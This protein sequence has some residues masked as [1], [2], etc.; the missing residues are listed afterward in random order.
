MK[1]IKNILFSVIA[2]VFAFCFVGCSPKNTTADFTAFNTNVHVETYDKS[3]SAETLNAV[4]KIL[5]NLEAKYSVTA[6]N[7]FTARF[8]ALDANGT[9]TAD[10]ETVFLFNRALTFGALT[11]GKFDFTVYPL[12]KAWRFSPEY[13]VNDF[14]PPT[15]MQI[16]ECLGAVGYGKV[17]V[18]GSEVGKTADGV[19]IDLGGFLKGYAT[20]LIAKKLKQVGVT[21]GYV[22]VG[23]SSLYLFDVDTL[24]VR[25]PENRYSSVLTVKKGLKTVCVSTSGTYERSYEYMGAT[26]THIINPSSGV[27]ADT[28]I[29]SATV[30][31]R[32]GAFADAMTTAL[33]LSS[34]DANNTECEFN[35]LVAKITETDAEA[36]VFAVYNKNGYKAI[37]TNCQDAAGFKIND[38]SYNLIK[39]NV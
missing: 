39:L 3:L 23:G 1:S 34:F 21:Q 28:G 27:P 32:D 33:C 35:R 29:L 25:H 30:I 17:Y 12:M 5:N 13:P 10:D 16:D 31:C 4:K 26:Y 8:N 2:I 9:L 24:D 36:V 22:N 20:D 6:E 15:Q 11:G 14:T 18:Q 38:A 37:V 19:Q 7:S